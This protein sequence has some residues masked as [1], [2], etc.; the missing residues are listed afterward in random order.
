[1]AGTSE[2]DVQLDPGSLSRLLRDTRA[3]DAEFYK[4]TRKRL[5]DAGQAG[6]KDVQNRLLT[7]T[8]HSNTGLRAGLA[9]GTKVSIKS[10]VR[11]AGVSITTTGAKLPAAK[12][13]MV[14]AYNQPSLRHPV[15]GRDVYVD[16][17]G[18]PYFGSVLDERKPDMARA[19]SM[20]LEDAARTISGADVR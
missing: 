9:A 11:T 5:R 7:A 1:M 4:S 17:R 19:V 14:K 10:G 16:Q 12:Q 6:V 20:A 15:F 2:I 18:R 3:F 8:S 13:A